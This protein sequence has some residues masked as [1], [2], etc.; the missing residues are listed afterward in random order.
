AMKMEHSLLAARDGVVGEVLVAAGE[1]V[2]AGAALIRLEE[3]A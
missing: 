3:E 2:S 1:Q